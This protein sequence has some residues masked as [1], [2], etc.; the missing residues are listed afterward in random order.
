[1]I[2]ALLT[3]SQNVRS[4]IYYGFIRM[5]VIFCSCLGFFS[6]F[7]LPRI[8]QRNVMI[9][10]LFFFLLYFAFLICVVW[11]MGT[12]FKRLRTG[13]AIHS[14][15]VFLFPSFIFLKLSLFGFLTDETQ[16]VVCKGCTLHR[17]GKDSSRSELSL[18]FQVRLD[19]F[20]LS[21]Y[22]LGIETP[23]RGMDKKEKNPWDNK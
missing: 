18:L 16:C 14:S 12:H 4:P 6:L 5:Y 3:S 1:M 7:F 20:L 10:I 22:H 8:F 11:Q 15:Y 9:F 13:N 23:G 17:A 21:Y 2:S 19:K